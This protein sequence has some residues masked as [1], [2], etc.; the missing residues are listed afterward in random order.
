MGDSWRMTVDYCKLNSVVA[1]TA[2]AIPDM[3]LLLE[4]GNTS[5]VPGIQLWIWQMPF[6]PKD[7]LEAVCFQLVRPAYTFTI[8]P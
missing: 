6:S 8:L 2:V 1:P 3:I 4:Q 5:L 7:P